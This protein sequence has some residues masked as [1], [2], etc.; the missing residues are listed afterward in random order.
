[1][2]RLPPCKQTVSPISLNSSGVVSGLRLE[3]IH[4]RESPF[5]GNCVITPQGELHDA[6]REF[7][8][9]FHEQVFSGFLTD[10]WQ[11][12]SSQET[13][14]L[15]KTTEETLGFRPPKLE[16]STSG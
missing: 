15:L 6:P 9:R 13:S 12:I 11:P 16:S 7:K 14:S 2:V 5:E 1:M 3:A 8:Q 4:S 10:G